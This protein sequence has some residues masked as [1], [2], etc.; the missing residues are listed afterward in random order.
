MKPQL[1]RAQFYLDLCHILLSTWPANKILL[2]GSTGKLILYK[3]SR[4]ALSHSVCNSQ[5]SKWIGV[6]IVILRGLWVFTSISEGLCLVAMV[7]VNGKWAL[8]ATLEIHNEPLLTVKDLR[9]TC[10][11]TRPHTMKS[12]EAFILREKRTRAS[13][14]GSQG[15]TIAVILVS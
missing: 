12:P 6:Q 5:P 11:E 15:E 10:G 7:T 1:W 2:H 4:L 13:M 14:F 9:V 3:E 8:S